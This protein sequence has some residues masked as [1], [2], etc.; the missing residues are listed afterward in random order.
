MYY[1][2]LVFSRYYL[3]NREDLLRFL[4]HYLERKASAR[5][6]VTV[7][8]NVLIDVVSER[9]RVYRI[10]RSRFLSALNLAI[11]DNRIDVMYTV[12]VHIFRTKENTDTALIS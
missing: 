12:N 4:G 8:F 5:S 6:T 10:S 9:S 1:V 2:N 11:G 7:T 3:T